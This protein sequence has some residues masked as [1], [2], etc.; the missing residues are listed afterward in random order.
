ME[1][2]LTMKQKEISRWLKAITLLVGCMGLVILFLIVPIVAGEMKMMYE[3]VAFLYWPGWIYVWGAGA[4]SYSCLFLFWKVCT[5][6]GKDNSFSRENAA[7][8]IYISRIAIIMAMYFF[9]GGV[10]ITVNGWIHL[11]I[12]FIFVICVLICVAVSVLAAA[13]SHLIRKAYEMKE[14]NELTI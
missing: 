6:I 5:E 8:F 9:F 12:L 3:E 4:L 11:A 14:E 10:A 1:R 2:M 7:Y 13:L